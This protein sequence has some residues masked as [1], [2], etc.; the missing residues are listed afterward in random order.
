MWSLV[1]LSPFVRCDE[2][3]LYALLLANKVLT[4]QA[5]DRPTPGAAMDK[6]H[7]DA[8]FHQWYMLQN[9]DI[10]GLD[11]HYEARAR[12][13]GF[14]TGWSNQDLYAFEADDR[15]AQYRSPSRIQEWDSST[16]LGA[17]TTPLVWYASKHFLEN[18]DSQGMKKVLEDV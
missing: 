9:S 5:D 16:F 8:P 2:E 12:I 4:L 3:R 1:C 7:L 6:V 14:L 11:R 13:E 10:W 15:K 17:P 18:T